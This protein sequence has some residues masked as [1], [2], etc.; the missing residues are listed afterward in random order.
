LFEEGYNTVLIAK[1]LKTSDSV[2]GGILKKHNLKARYNK[3]VLS[4]KDEKIICEMYLSGCTAKIILNKFSHIYKSENAIIDILKRNN[5]PI[6][7]AGS[8]NKTKNHNCFEN[9]DTEEKAYFLGLLLT[10]GCV[11]KRKNHHVIILELKEEDKYIIEKFKMFVDTE[12]NI[13][14]SRKCN[15]LCIH[16]DKMANDL[17]KYGIVP[18]K[19]FITELPIIDLDLMP[20]L[21]RGIIDGDGSVHEAFTKNKSKK[22]LRVALYGTHKLCQQVLDFLGLEMTVYDKKDQHVSFFL[23]SRLDRTL[24]FYNYLYKDATIFLKRKKVIFDKYFANTE[25]TL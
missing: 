4:L 18:R 7:S 8:Y 5:I 16:S 10:D 14:Y 2:I 25:R 3:Y 1:Q 23:T 19:T 13:I 21:I 22:V 9:I 6:R 12:N 15:K 11:M 24:F 20:H 17:A